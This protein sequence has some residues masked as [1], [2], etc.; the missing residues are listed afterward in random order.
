MLSENFKDR[1]SA[2]IQ[3]FHTKNV[4]KVSNDRILKDSTTL[5]ASLHV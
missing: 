2:L 5:S 3:Q 4:L 1:M